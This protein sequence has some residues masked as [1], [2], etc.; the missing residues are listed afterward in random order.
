[1]EAITGPKLT[2]YMI[3]KKLINENCQ[4][5][6]NAVLKT[7]H[8]K[9][10]FFWTCE[11]QA[12]YFWNM[13]EID[14]CV[15]F[16]LQKLIDGFSKGCVRHYFIREINLLSMIPQE[17][18][19]DTTKELNLMKRDLKIKRISQDP[20]TKAIAIM[21]L[22]SMKFQYDLDTEQLHGSEIDIRSDM[23][24]IGLSLIRE[25]S[26][27][28][29]DYASVAC[30]S[31]NMGF[32]NQSQLYQIEET[33]SCCYAILSACNEKV[34]SLVMKCKYE[35]Q[36]M[37]AL[38]NKVMD[39]MDKPQI[40]EE[41]TK[42]YKDQPQMIDTL[43]ERVMQHKDQPPVIE[44]LIMTCKGTPRIIEELIMEYKNQQHVIEE[45]V[46]KFQDELL[47][48]CLLKEWKDLYDTYQDE[49]T[50][51]YQ[52]DKFK[53]ITEIEYPHGRYDDDLCPGE[54]TYYPYGEMVLKLALSVAELTIN[55]KIESLLNKIV[56][57]E[58]SSDLDSLIDL[59]K[60]VLPDFK[61][62]G[63]GHLSVHQLAQQ[64]VCRFDIP[65]DTLL[66]QNRP[67]LES[68]QG[69]CWQKRLDISK[70]ILD[71]DSI[72][73]ITLYKVTFRG[74]SSIYAEG[75]KLE[76]LGMLLLLGK[77]K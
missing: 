21:E 72:P 43:L 47:I 2:T 25:C 11:E 31:A 60:H 33:L 8:L 22:A 65:F 44:Q 66:Q 51:Q 49:S 54:I 74:Q 39:Y 63:E 55:K 27:Y 69:N 10:V 32:I 30:Y 34:N 41:F 28:I 12:S 18:L 36:A 9:T 42:G 7:Y 14:K 15:F 38:F 46:T 16:V 70:G 77:S 35:H 37:E 20:D 40:I 73:N 56:L 52:S 59:F 5:G 48:E 3:L 26:P 17:A 57:S 13:E 45:L 61:W 24:F 76:N 67:K 6:E 4:L 64:G 75:Q 58:E 23:K 68:C 19:Q 53:T 1:M 29:S 50:E 62:S 71:S